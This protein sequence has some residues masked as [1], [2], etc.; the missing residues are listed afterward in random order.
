MAATAIHRGRS[1]NGPTAQGRS[2]RGRSRSRARANHDPT[3]K[4]TPDANRSEVHGGPSG[5]ASVP[6]LT[7]LVCSSTARWCREAGSLSAQA[8]LPDL[9]AMAERS[10]RRSPTG[11]PEQTINYQSE[12]GTP[13]SASA[14]RSS[15]RYAQ[16]ALRAAS[17]APCNPRL[18][19]SISFTTGRRSSRSTWSSQ[20]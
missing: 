1:W 5:L 14:S 11:A 10:T 17:I 18:G 8:I 20:P 2:Q 9:K 6:R 7:S 16:P 15:I 3:V 13:S 19:C 12:V 4:V